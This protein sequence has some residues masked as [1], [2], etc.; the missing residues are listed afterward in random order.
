MS[1]T[2]TPAPWSLGNASRMNV[3]GPDGRVIC[4]V[5]SLADAELIVSMRDKLHQATATLAAANACI[6]E[7]ERDAEWRPIETAPKDGTV[8]RVKLSKGRTLFAAWRRV[9]LVGKGWFVEVP[10]IDGSTSGAET[11][12]THADDQ[13]THWKPQSRSSVT[14]ADSPNAPDEAWRSRSLQPDV[15]RSEGA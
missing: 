8:I 13:P 4:S 11:L 3:C 2:P 7:L 15:G 9:F 10:P 14:V 5:N 6:A 1:D 12:L